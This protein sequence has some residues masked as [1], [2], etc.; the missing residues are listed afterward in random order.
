MCISGF[1]MKRNG[2]ALMALFHA[3]KAIREISLVR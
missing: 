3:K 2:N 1:S